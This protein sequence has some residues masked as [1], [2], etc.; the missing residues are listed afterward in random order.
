MAA[1]FIHVET[2]F[3]IGLM[4]LSMWL[5]PGGDG[6]SVFRYSGGEQWEDIGEA[7]HNGRSGKFGC[8]QIHTLAVYQGALTLGTW[9]DGKVL[10]SWGKGLYTI[11]H[12]IRIDPQGKAFGQMALEMKIKVPATLADKLKQ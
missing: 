7:F 5:V 3:V 4:G 11:P 12:S 9:P 10:R 8:D 2:A 1:A 6:A